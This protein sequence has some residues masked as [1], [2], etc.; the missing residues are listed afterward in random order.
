MKLILGLFIIFTTSISYSVMADDYEDFSWRELRAACKGNHDSDAC[1][2]QREKARAHCA[3]HADKK[4]CR[5]LNAL[6][7]CKH[8]PDSKVC[9]QHKEK[10]KAYCKEHPGAKKCVRARIHKICKDDPESEECISAKENA[11]AKFCEKHPD[12]ERCN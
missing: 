8:N 5:K 7:E 12:S 6:K 10:F 2:E 9:Q 1:L 3:E 11:H 4:R